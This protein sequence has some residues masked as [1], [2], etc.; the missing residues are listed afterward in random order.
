MLAA[1][2]SVDGRPWVGIGQVGRRSDDLSVS[3]GNQQQQASSISVPPAKTASLESDSTTCKTQLVSSLA[4]TGEAAETRTYG[5]GAIIEYL[6]ILT[7]EGNMYDSST[8][9]VTVPESGVYMIGLRADPAGGIND[10]LYTLLMV[11]GVRTLQNNG[12]HGVI[13]GTMISLRLEAGDQVWLEKNGNGIV[14]PG[15]LLSVTRVSV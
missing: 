1:T 14:D 9:I 2:Y 3:G 7:D 5:H 10:Y 12:E 6:N 8:G 4:F 15:T 13:S 11:N